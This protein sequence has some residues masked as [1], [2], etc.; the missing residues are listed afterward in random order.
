VVGCSVA[1]VCGD[2]Q[3]VLSFS[4]IAY[5]TR[6]SSGTVRDFRWSR[7]KHFAPAE[8]YS[9]VSEHVFPFLRTLGGDKST[10]AHH[11]KD[12][13]FTIPTA[14]LLARVVDLIADVPMEDR[15]TKGDLYEYMLG[16]IANER[17]ESVWILSRST[18][19]QT[20]SK[21]R[22]LRKCSGRAFQKLAI[23]TVSRSRQ[24]SCL[25]NE[26]DVGSSSALRLDVGVLCLDKSGDGN[27]PLP[28][29]AIACDI[30]RDHSTARTIGQCVGCICSNRKIKL[31][32][33]LFSAISSPTI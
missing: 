21:P 26:A 19:R 15:D 3:L 12:A 16:K 14:G 23:G 13:R 32:S 17:S 30:E 25:R 10:Y 11:M 4:R 31:G 6:P 9:L 1:R 5:W 22:S 2:S 29:P 27:S 24:L 20:V 28:T 18:S 33:Q 7:F 8:M